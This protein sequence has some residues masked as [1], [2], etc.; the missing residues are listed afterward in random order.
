MKEIAVM[1]SDE[2]RHANPNKEHVTERVAFSN[3]EFGSAGFL[4][5]CTSS[6]EMIESQYRSIVG[7][8]IHPN[9]FTTGISWPKKTLI[10]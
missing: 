8:K 3:I 10:Y 6:S 7:Q 4:V 2:D 9:P 1:K 5:E